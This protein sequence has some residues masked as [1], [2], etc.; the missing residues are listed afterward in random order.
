MLVVMFSDPLTIRPAMREDLESIVSLTRATRRQLAQWAPVYFNPT[1]EADELHAAFLEFMVD[2][3]D[4]V[5]KMLTADGEPIGFFAEH[6]LAGEP[7]TWVDDL[8]IAD[9]SWWPSAIDAINNEFTTP[10]VT[11]V[12]SRDIPRSQAM[13]ERGHGVISSYWART[14]R[15]ITPVAPL[16]FTSSDFD[17]KH[18]APHT[19]GGQAFQ[20][21][22]P[23]ALVV[24]SDAGFA[25][26]SPSATPPIYDPGGPTTVIDQINGPD[27]P[28]VVQMSLAAAKDRSD[29]QVVVVCRQKDAELV[30]IVEEAGFNRVVDLI[31]R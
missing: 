4:V 22:L 24:G 16:D 3:D 7:R 5:T 2:A 21:D 20:P 31:G 23:G 15:D 8:C 27:R 11:C 13:I 18:A 12:S 25:I 1:A 14:T 6:T 29:A 19:F 30:N 9:A 28:R 17:V 10:W 26:G